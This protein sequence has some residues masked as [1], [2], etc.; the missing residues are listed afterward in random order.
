MRTILDFREL[1]YIITVA[2]HQNLSKAAQELYVSQP[3]LTK[4]I[5]QHEKQLGIKI[6]QRL[7]NRFCLTYAGE[8]YIEYA[9]QILLLK[10]EMDTEMTDL[11]K[12][13]KGRLNIAYPQIRSSYMVPVTIPEFRLRYPH[14]KI[15]LYEEPS[16][17]LEELLISGKA[18]IAIFNH[19]IKN[20]DLQYEVLAREEMTL[21]VS[22]QH[23]LAD[24][25]VFRSDCHYPWIDIKRFKEDAFILN[26]S[27]QRTGQ[28]A[29]QIFMGNNINPPV[30]L[31]TRSIE[32]AVRLAATGFG[33]CFVSESHLK[34]FSLT[35]KPVYFSVGNPKTIVE[36]VVAYRRGAY[37]PQYT[38]DYIQ[39]VKDKVR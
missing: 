23:P 11:A 17:I 27:D 14:V 16:T 2:K 35:N 25:G 20:H 32:G 6:Y 34:Y 18:D 28:I 24:K 3:T 13:D 30:S 7:G 33:L 31:E 1:Q 19:P 15:K 8:R 29:R 26:M 4:F 37:L 9:K 12:Q 5:Q 38:K 10:Q 39:I 21:A 36:L 22:R